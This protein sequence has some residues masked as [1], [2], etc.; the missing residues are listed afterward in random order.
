MK[1]TTIYQLANMLL[2][3]MM[4]VSCTDCD[5]DTHSYSPTNIKDIGGGVFYAIN[6]A[7]NDT[8]EIEGGLSVSIGGSPTLN[9]ANGN[10]I[11]L[12]FEQDEKYK[13]YKFITTYTLHDGTEIKNQ[14]TYEYAI[15]NTEPGNYRI[16][17]SAEYIQKDDNHD[18]SIYSGGGFV[19][20]ILK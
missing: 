20:N 10:I 16:S 8:L 12:V 13:D 15:S 2:L 6:V 9:A 11:K 18:I 3:A 1:K 19:L 7:T 14:P 4:L 17:M 5:N